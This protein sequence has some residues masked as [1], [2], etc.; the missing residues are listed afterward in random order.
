MKHPSAGA[1]NGGDAGVPKYSPTK[2]SRE[3]SKVL[4]E[5]I[6]SLLGKRRP[7]EDDLVTG[8]NRGKRAKP[9]AR[10]KVSCWTHLIGVGDMLNFP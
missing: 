7:S 10:T 5:S 4:Q 8:V 1:N 6:T 2:I 3:T 9:I